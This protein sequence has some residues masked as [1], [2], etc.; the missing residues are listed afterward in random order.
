[1]I[2][3]EFFASSVNLF[4]KIATNFLEKAKNSL[5][6][7]CFEDIIS[8]MK[9]ILLKIQPITAACDAYK[10]IINQALVYTKALGNW[11]TPT[12]AEANPDRRNIILL[13]SL[14]A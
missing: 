7:F 11:H 3:T 12:V 1:M 4:G 9:V 5:R 8:P 13:T 14:V 10:M 2:F 6:I